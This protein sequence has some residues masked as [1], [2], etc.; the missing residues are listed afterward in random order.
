MLLCCAASSGLA[1][2][3]SRPWLAE[4][5]FWDYTTPG[6]GGME[7]YGKGDYAALLDDMAEAGMNSLL[8]CPRWFTTGYRSRLAYLDQLPTNRV[9]A[10]GNELLRWV[11]DE[12]RKRKIKT[13]LSAY[14]CGFEPRVY[15]LKPYRTIKVPIDGAPTVE[16]GIY[17]LDTPGVAERGV[18]IFDELAREFPMA[19]ALNVELEDS[20]IELPHRIPLYNKWAAETGRPPF[21]R[22]GH[23]LSPRLYDVPAWRDYDTHRR[24]QVLQSIEAAVRARGFRGDLGMICETA[25]SAYSITQEVNLREYHARL[26]HWVAVTYEYDKWRHRYGVM[27]L[28]IA[29]PKK[30]GLKVYY[31]PRGVMT[32]GRWPLPITLEESWDMDVED[33]TR[34]RPDGLWWFGSG[35]VNEGLHVSVKKLREAGYSD[36]RAARRALLKK[37]AALRAAATA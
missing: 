19:G 31:L 26:P 21:E 27:D 35:G 23:P 14:V 33:V 2:A 32:W 5:G 8:I 10:S 20:G 1:P 37:A 4:H 3:E 29:T 6:A 22:L 16:I 15:G 18:E 9:I 7:A 30:E 36:G 13:W 11:L 28:S 17:D 25:N 24:I 34:F 12:A